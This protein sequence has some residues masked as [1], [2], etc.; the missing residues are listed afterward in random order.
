[1]QKLTEQGRQR[2]NDLAQRYGVSTDA[3]MV[4]LQALIKGNG[5]MAQFNHPELGGSGQ[6]LQGGMTMVGDMFNH[7]LKAK[8]DGLCT[9][10]CQLLAQQ[11]PQSGQSQF[12]G[13]QQQQQ[14]GGSG[15]AGI[16]GG[17]PAVSLFIPAA[18]GSSGNWWPAEL[19][20]P[21]GIGSQ[22]NIRYAYFS[23]ARRLAVEINGH[24]TVYDTLDHQISGVSQQQQGSGASLTF[25]SQH[26]TIPVASLP[27]VSIDGASQN[28]AAQTA[29][30]TTPAEPDRAGTAP[31]RDI[32]AQ[33]ERLAELERKG[34]LSKEEF[35]AKKS[36]L[37]GRL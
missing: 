37:L 20:S 5:T 21:S 2:I 26:G 1:L 33:I 12:Q 14:Q 16:F 32:F 36:E 35:A 4:L 15:S 24:V 17:G 10:L 31:E 19:G 6:W 3:V 29:Q 34:I 23:K 27:V 9:E 11:P 25:T 7:S 18:Q 30:T 28:A 8:V 22:N 13:G